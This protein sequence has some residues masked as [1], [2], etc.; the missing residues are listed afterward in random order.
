M[1]LVL[2]WN[3]L[4]DFMFIVI[5]TGDIS[6]ERFLEVGKAGEKGVN[7]GGVFLL[8]FEHIREGVDS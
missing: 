2:A 5:S 4:K 8:S 6:V 1:P 3:K 7:C